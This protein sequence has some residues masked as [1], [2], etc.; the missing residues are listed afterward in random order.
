MAVLLSTRNETS[1]RKAGRDLG[2]YS[3]RGRGVKVIMLTE[4]E[5]VF[6]NG[7]ETDEYGHPK[8]GHVS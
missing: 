4:E 3:S 1:S 8:T 7:G 2:L 6:E 5:E